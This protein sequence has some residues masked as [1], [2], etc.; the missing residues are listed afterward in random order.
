MVLDQSIVAIL[1]DTNHIYGHTCLLMQ[2]Q[3]L[4]NSTDDDYN[5][6]ED[7]DDGDDGDGAGDG[8]AALVLV[9]VVVLVVVLP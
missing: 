7:S 4:L 9:L 5:D 2:I 6:C 8:G 1:M 3:F